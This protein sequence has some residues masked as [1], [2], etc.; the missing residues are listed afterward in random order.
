MKSTINMAIVLVFVLSSALAKEENRKE[1]FSRNHK[2]GICGI[3]S[4]RLPEM[5]DRKLSEFQ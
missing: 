2:E 5:V 3:D 4:Q 1:G